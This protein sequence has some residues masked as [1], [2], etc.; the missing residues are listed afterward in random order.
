MEDREA[1][2]R[3][4]VA[5]LGA[6]SAAAPPTTA[7]ELEGLIDIYNRV[8]PLQEELNRSDPAPTAERRAEIERELAST[9]ESW[10]HSMTALDGFF[11][12]LKAECNKAD[13]APDW[14]NGTEL[15]TFTLGEVGTVHFIEADSRTGIA[16]MC[17]V[18]DQSEPQASCTELMTPPPLGSNE[19]RQPWTS[20]RLPTPAGSLMMYFVALPT[21]HP[22]PVTVHDASGVLWPS[23]EPIDRDTLVFIDPE[24]VTDPGAVNSAAPILRQALD[25]L[26]PDG[27]LLTRIVSPSPP[28]PYLGDWSGELADCYRAN[29]LAYSS[30]GTS[31]PPSATPPSTPPSTPLPGDLALAAWRSCRHIFA[32]RPDAGSTNPRSEPAYIECMVAQGWLPPF[33]VHNVE[34]WGPASVSCGQDPDGL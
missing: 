4:I 6:L 18:F 34:Q 26:G 17:L 19:S 20:P 2:Y 1:S 31:A 27:A 25:V 9:R 8:G 16:F 12:S 24:P 11:E 21:G 29:G 23:A 5:A 15:A 3:D 22:R 14:Q 10:I 7:H 13:N 28:S 30:A 32:K 33:W